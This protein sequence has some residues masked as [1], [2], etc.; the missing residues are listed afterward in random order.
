V[1]PALVLNYLGQGAL[2][3]QN[4]AG[5]REPVLLPRTARH[6]DPPSSCSR[7]MA[8]VIASQALISGAFSLTQQAVQ[9]GLRRGSPSCTRAHEA[10]QIF[11]PKS[12]A[13][14]WSRLLLV[15][16]FPDVDVAWSRPTASP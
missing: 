8:A 16:A 12:I 5:N 15:I 1:L 7:R 14:S 6:V 2:L 4:P 11:I 3:L 9:L 10:G 13:C